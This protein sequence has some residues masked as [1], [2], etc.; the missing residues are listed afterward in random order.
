MATEWQDWERWSN[1]RVAGLEEG[2]TTEWQNCE[3]EEQP[4]G[5]TGSGGGEQPSGMTGRGRNSR[6]AGLGDSEE[7]MTCK[8]L[9]TSGNCLTGEKLPGVEQQNIFEQNRST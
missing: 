1:N 8:G 4:S 7:G 2:G 9:N 6:V 3:R 5:R